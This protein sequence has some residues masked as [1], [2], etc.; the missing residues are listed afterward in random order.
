MP[1]ARDLDQHSWRPQRFG[2]RRARQ[3]VDPIIEPLWSGERILVHLDGSRIDIIDERGTRL[4]VES[5][6]IEG[7]GSGEELGA[8]VDE[9]GRGVRADS[10]VLDGYLTRQPTRQVEGLLLDPAMRPPSAAE[11]TSRLF[12]G[13]AARIRQL[14]DRIPDPSPE[15]AALALVVVDLLAIDGE[16]LLDVPLLERKR[17]LD[18]AL[19]E[20][21]LVR[22]TAFVRPPVDHWLRSW[23]TLGFRSLAYKAANSRYEPGADNDAWA[24]VAMPRH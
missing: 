20:S 8:I 23:R 15:E 14:E 22:R 24:V 21:G 9:V 4:S 17:L 18:T 2:R 7:I 5:V 3:I 6:S 1:G 12:L 13:A 16:P 10:L 11:S 19:D